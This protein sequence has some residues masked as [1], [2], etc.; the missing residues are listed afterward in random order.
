MTVRELIL[1]CQSQLLSDEAE[2]EARLMVAHFMKMTPT[3]L[4][5]SYNQAVTDE[6]VLQCQKTV[7]R[8]NF[9]EP[10]QYILGECEFFGLTF[11]VGK[12][13]LIPRQ[14]T[15]LLVETA[16]ELIKDKKTPKV[17]DL[18]S[19]SGCVAIS[20]AKNRQD[21]K[22]DAVELYDEA[23]GYLLKNIDSNKATNVTPIKADALSFMGDYDLVVSNPPYIA[24]SEKADLSK[25]VLNEPET[26]LFTDDEGLL[27][28]KTISNNFANKCDIAFE[29]GYRQ[30]K[31]VS[32]ILEKLGANTEISQ[33][34]C[35]NDRV[36]IGK[37]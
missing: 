36:V 28:Y 30:G 14:D 11:S 10:L 2:R 33:D 8:R 34:L 22:V 19:G 37:Y 13:V 26:A 21:A 7:E 25:E 29:I 12:G 4:R 17:L 23:Y 24:H 6:V 18:C 27:F 31:A 35:G 3:A 16:L 20:I 15:E 32:G 5:M 1:Q 9:G